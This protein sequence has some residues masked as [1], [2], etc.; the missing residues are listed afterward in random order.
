MT[1]NRRARWAL[2]IAL[3]MLAILALGFGTA[4]GKKSD[5]SAGTKAGTPAAANEKGAAT[6]AAK[7]ASTSAPAAKGGDDSRDFAQLFERYK[8]AESRVDYEFSMTGAAALSGTMS[9][10]QAAGR[11]RI[12]FASPQG[13]LIFIQLPDKSYMCLAEQRTCLDAGGAAGPGGPASNP[14]LTAVQDFNT[15][16]AGYTNRELDRRRI[17][18]LEARCFENSSPRGDKSVTCVG[19]EGQLLL[20]EFTAAGQ[21]TKMTATKVEGKPAAAD[22]EPP[23]PVTSLSGLG[24]FGGPG[25]PGGLPTPPR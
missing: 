11:M 12:D 8:N 19:P 20:A 10:R 17:A 6:A 16:A 5:D 22:F 13:T 3:P 25:V 9:M 7:G 24:G 21:T 1:N 4:C 15:N 18:G 23:Y 2:A 14:L